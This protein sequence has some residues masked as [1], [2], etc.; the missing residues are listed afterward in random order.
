M[1][2][3]SPPNP[4][5]SQSL[6]VY[7]A[8]SF[9]VT[10]GANLG[11]PITDAS[12][13]AL[14]DVYGLRD[15]EN[16]TRLAVSFE[17]DR[18]HFT[19]AEGTEAGQVGANLY[20]D[21]CATF[22][23]PDG[24]TIEAIILVETD[25]DL[26]ANSYI[27][28]LA[29]LEIDKDYALVKIDKGAAVARF[30]EVACVSFTRGTLITLANGMQKPIEDLAL[31]DKVLT[32]DNGPREIRWIGQQTVRATGA[33]APIVIHK[34]VLNNEN[35]LT[36]SP[37]HRLFIYQRRDHLHTGRAEVMVKARLLVNGETVVQ[38]DGGYVDY[39][40]L[41]FDGHEIIYAEGIAA[42]SLFV[43]TRVKPVLPP[44][45]REQLAGDGHE[46]GRAPRAFELGEGSIDSAT[47]ADLLRRASSS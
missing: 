33:F 34:G 32:R 5:T 46:T 29:P 14:D 11:D 28:P 13:M 9:R 1:S 35:D 6:P 30:A 37:N 42:E 44:E 19:I 24:A 31:G 47:A 12:D 15:V 17:A 40:Q 45:L 16:R 3:I 36:L 22:M 21:C 10:N 25:G 20:L 18:K 26:V 41:M 4:A 2:E 8:E 27:L 23:C 7:C 43:D 38:S 39:F